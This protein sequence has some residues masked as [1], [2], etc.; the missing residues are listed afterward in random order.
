M[1][2]KLLWKNVRH[3]EG[4]FNAKDNS[5]CI[6]EVFADGN[7]TPVAREDLVPGDKNLVTMNRDLDR[8]ALKFTYKERLGPVYFGGARLSVRPKGKQ[9]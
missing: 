5:R 4:Q 8:V 9:A 7:A 6:V 3:I 1:G 2:D